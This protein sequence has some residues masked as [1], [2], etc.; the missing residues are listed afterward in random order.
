MPTSDSRPNSKKGKEDF[1]RDLKLLMAEVDDESDTEA[2]AMMREKAEG[3]ER[4]RA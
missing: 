4:A 1:R 3:T 2:E